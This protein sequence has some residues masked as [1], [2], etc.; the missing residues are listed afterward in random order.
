LIE[1]VSGSYPK[2]VGARSPLGYQKISRADLYL[3]MILK[4]ENIMLRNVLSRIIVLAV[5]TLMTSCAP[6]GPV[7]KVEQP[8]SAVYVNDMV[9]IPVKVENIANLTAIEVHL[10]FDTS[11]LEVVQLND[12]GFIQADFVPQ[13]IFDN[14]AGT[15]D[16]A[17]AQIN[18]EPASGSGMIFEIV[19]RAKTAGE[20]LIS[21]REIPAALAGALLS[22]SNGMAIRVSLTGGNVS[23]SQP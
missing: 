17:V 12:G 19:F 14:T 11:V 2:N 21:F 9:T 6:A 23:V 8:A 3:A 22:D 18:R 13:N 5:L 20:S 15:I 4:M 16:Y 10:S 7:I 1:S